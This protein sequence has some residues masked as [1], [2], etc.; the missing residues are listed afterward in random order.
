MQDGFIFYDTVA[1]NIAF[2]GNPIDEDAMQNAVK[3]ANLDDFMIICRLV[4]RQK[5]AAL[6]WELVGDKGSGF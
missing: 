6:V 1:R 2:D 5:S 4:L 3:V